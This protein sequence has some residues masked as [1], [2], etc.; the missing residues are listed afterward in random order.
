MHEKRAL[1]ERLKKYNKSLPRWQEVKLEFYLEVDSVLHH[2][3]L[4]FL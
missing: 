3:F 4:D 2:C 1:K